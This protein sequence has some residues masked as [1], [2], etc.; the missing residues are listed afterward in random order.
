MNKDKLEKFKFNENT[1]SEKVMNFLGMKSKQE[2]EFK[3][4]FPETPYF[5]ND[6]LEWWIN[7]YLEKKVEG[8]YFMPG[9]AKTTESKEEYIDYALSEIG[10]KFRNIYIDF[11]HEGKSESNCQEF[12]VRLR[13]I[14]NRF[15]EKIDV[16]QQAFLVHGRFKGKLSSLTHHW[17]TI[18]DK[19]S[20]ISSVEKLKNNT[21]YD[22]TIDQ[23]KNIEGLEFHQRTRI[24]DL[25]FATINRESDLRELYEWREIYPAPKKY[26]QEENK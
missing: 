20:D 11:A 22:G 17:V 26:F 13:D 25:K 24:S 10:Y 1:M 18:G 6:L 23:F 16:N 19:S 4:M 9:L 7:S 21:I 8:N 14:Y 2:K 15:L 5:I 12:S 3:K